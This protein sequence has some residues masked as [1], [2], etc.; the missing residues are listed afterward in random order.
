M[1]QVQMQGRF[2]FDRYGVWIEV[3][4]HDEKCLSLLR[5]MARRGFDLVLF[6]EY[7]ISYSVLEKMIFD[8]SLWPKNQKLW[9]LPCQGISV[10]DFEGFMSRVAGKQG[11]FVLDRA[12]MSPKVNQH[13]F[14]TAL[15]S[16]S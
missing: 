6:P 9:V 5:I 2:S 15:F 3:P 11:V 16:V 14:V 13:S 1:L 10:D 4:E 12:W 7:C 8:C